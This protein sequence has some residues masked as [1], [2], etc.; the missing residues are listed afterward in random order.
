[1]SALIQALRVAEYLNFR[2]A[3]DALGVSQSSVSAR[4]MSLENDLGVQ[5]LAST[6][7]YG[8]HSETRWCPTGL[9]RHKYRHG[10]RFCIIYSFVSVS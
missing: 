7:H 10:Q 2:H 3:A 6:V 8:S 4:V 9:R 5:G 1:M